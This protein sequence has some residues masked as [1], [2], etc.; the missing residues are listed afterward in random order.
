MHAK[1]CEPEKEGQRRCSP[2]IKNARKILTTD[3]EK[4]EMLNNFV[5]QSSLVASFPILLRW[6]GSRMGARGAKS[7]LM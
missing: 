4:A 1:V 6:M 2:L 3:E 5:T 7:L